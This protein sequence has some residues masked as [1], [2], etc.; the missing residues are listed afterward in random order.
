MKPGEVNMNTGTI[1]VDDLDVIRVK[2]DAEEEEGNSWRSKR[3]RTR[4]NSK[5]RGQ[6]HWKLQVWSSSCVRRSSGFGIRRIA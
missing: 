5:Q 1:S 2:V 3:S 4:K 6:R